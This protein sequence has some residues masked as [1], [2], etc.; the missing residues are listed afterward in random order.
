MYWYRA[1]Q[2][3]SYVPSGQFIGLV[4]TTIFILTALVAIGVWNTPKHFVRRLSIFSFFVI[5]ALLNSAWCYLFFYK[6]MM[7][8]AIWDAAL[9]DFSVIILILLIKPLSRIYA[10]LLFPYALWVTYALYLNYVIWS[11]N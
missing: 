7:G 5:N 1:I 6:K 2:L 10:A 8:I 3:P 4:W 11:I 9:L